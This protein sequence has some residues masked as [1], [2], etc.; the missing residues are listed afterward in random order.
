MPVT[1]RAQTFIPT[2]TAPLQLN[3]VLVS[4]SLIKNLISV[5]RL[6]RDN[7]VAIEFDPSGF[8]IKDLPTR[9]EM[10]RCES[11]GDLYPLRLPQ[12][13]ALTASS[14]TSLW[15]QRLGHP[16]HPVTA[17]VLQTF[18]FHCNKSDAHSCSSCRLGKHARLPF[19]DSTTQIFFPFQIVHSD[20]WTS[21]VYNHSGYK[22]YIV[23]LDDY[24][25][26]LWTI[27]LRNKSD[28]LPTVRAFISY[29]HTQFRLPILAFQTD[30]GREYDSTAMRLLLS[31][32]GTQLRLSCPYTSQQNGKAER[33]LRT[34]NDCVH[35]MMI[36]SAAP[37]AFW[38]E[39]LATATYLINRRPCRATGTTTPYA[40]LFGVSPSYTELRVFGC[41]CFPNLIATSATSL[42][43]DPLRASSSG[44][45]RITAAIAATTSTRVG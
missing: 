12:H 41:Q 19:S 23:F 30:N 15:H 17:Q 11:S 22:Y 26:Y 28:V 20:V 1:H 29:V 25:H 43:L 34:I 27:P 10:L 3:D 8:S 9:E 40:M 31:S 16:G 7:N 39:A 37:L 5:R 21:P 24:T 18:P 4:P 33:V 2:A 35:T 14:A 42:P 36:H 32:L 45:R 38:A 13:Q 6:T 44:T